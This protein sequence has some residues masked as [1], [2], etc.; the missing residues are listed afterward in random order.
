MLPPLV[1]LLLVFA[2][3]ALEAS[4]QALD[5]IDGTPVLDLKPYMTEFGPRASAS[6]VPRAHGRVLGTPAPSP[7]PDQVS[8]RSPSSIGQVA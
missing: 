8:S 5:A 6:L 1:A 7:K 2:L 4:A 3:P